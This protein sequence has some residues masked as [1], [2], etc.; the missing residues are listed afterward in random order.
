MGTIQDRRHTPEPPAFRSAG[1]HFK[2]QNGW[3]VRLLPSEPIGAELNYE[4]S[5]YDPDYRALTFGPEAANTLK[6]VSSDNTVMILA[7]V[8]SFGAAT[9]RDKTA[10]FLA[11]LIAL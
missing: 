2:F 3:Q 8:R 10:E 4:V 5:I 9:K 7:A 1:T 6:K 11:N